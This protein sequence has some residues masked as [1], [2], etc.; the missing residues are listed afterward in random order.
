MTL[1][2]WKAWKERLLQASWQVAVAALFV[3]AHQLPMGRPALSALDGSHLPGPGARQRLSA[4][5][6]KPAAIEAAAVG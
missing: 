1:K 3:A 4:S 2:P 5:V 6:P